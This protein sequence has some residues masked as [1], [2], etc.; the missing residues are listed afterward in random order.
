MNSQRISIAA[1]DSGSIGAY[2]SL[3]PSG[4]GPGIIVLQ[5]IFGVNHHIRAVTDRWA[6]EGYV[7]LAPDIFWRVEP[8]VELDYTPEGMTKGLSKWDAALKSRGINPG[9][10]AD[11]TVATLFTSSLSSMRRHICSATNLPSRSKDD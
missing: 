10:S 8:G 3:P 2:L 1:H 4:R 6:A 11:L 9:T 7:A 5:E